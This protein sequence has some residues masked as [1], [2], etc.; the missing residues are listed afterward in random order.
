MILERINEPG[1]LKGLSMEQLEQLAAEVRDLIVRT[2]SQTGGHLASS[3]GTVE[4]TVALHAV[5]DSPG[6]KIIW[7]V[8][9]QAY[10]H[11]ILTGRRDR[12]PS[13][14][15]FGGISGFLKRDESMHDI[16]GAGHSSTSVSAALG[17]ATARDLAGESHEVIAVIGDGAISAGMA[18][19]AM[20]HAGHLRRDMIVIL[21]DNEMSISQNVGALAGY[22]SRLRLDPGLARL[23]DEVRTFVRQFPL[24]GRQAFEAAEY[25]ESHLAYFLV[26]GALFEV[27]GFTYLGPFD[28]HDI[29]KLMAIFKRTRKVRGPRLIHV[30]TQKGHGY[31]PAEQDATRFHGA[32][33]FDISTGESQQSAAK[34]TY[35]DVFGSTLVELAARDQRVVAITAA[36]CNGTGLDQFSRTY[37][38]RFFDVGIAEQHAVTFGAAMALGGRRPVVAI[39]STFLQRAYDQI[40]HD[41]CLQNLPLVLAIDRA[42]C[43]GADGATHQGVFDISFLRAVPNLVIMAPADENELRHM[44]YTA[45][46][47]EGPVAI[48]YPRDRI[49]GL[50]P[51]RE[52]VFLEPGQGRILQEGDD[53]A[54][55]AVGSMVSVAREA[56]K[57]LARR[58]VKATV[59]DM[60]YIK[61]LDEKL[62]V[63]CAQ[64]S[65]N[66]ITIEENVAAGGMGSAVMELLQA[67]EVEG[68]RIHCLGFPDQFVEHGSIAQTRAMHGLSVEGI[69]AAA[70][71]L[72]MCAPRRGWVKKLMRG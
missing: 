58:G 65:H 6:D 68:V 16:F 47:L 19:E 5:F 31:V 57:E 59:A 39:Y 2:V 48:R 15:Q 24:I 49:L 67:R 35:T 43:V 61:P 41:V 7:D 23:R 36:M 50:P 37:P 42:G 70:A 33:P 63:S 21:N 51:A 40:I 52:Y 3:L 62:V 18:F 38:D 13:L 17:L 4:L 32:L 29:E 69:L 10:A 28:G 72:G 55:L 54:I 12:F 34:V 8:G 46:R 30:L 44:L 14:R 11:K 71:R 53:L 56:G 64:R 66:L 9:H 25:L 20:N 26:P 60:R 1:D 22:L 45:L 27:L